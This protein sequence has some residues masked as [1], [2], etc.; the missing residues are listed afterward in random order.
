M[1]DLGPLTYFLGLEFVH[2][3]SGIRV[4]QHKYTTDL[5]TSARLDD[6]NIFVMPMELNNKISTDDGSPLADPSIFRQIVGSLLY[7]T[8]IKPDISYAVHTVN[9][10][11]SNP[12]KPHLT[13]A[14]HI[15]CYVKGTLNHGIFYPSG[16]SLHLTAYA[17][18]DWGGCL[19][20]RRSTTV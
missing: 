3:K 9:Q 18:T 13:A 6:A 10:F 16:V 5:I 7:L 15:R 8:M 11:V 4:H 2:N 12:H 1:K 17:N 20:T 14:L 19:N